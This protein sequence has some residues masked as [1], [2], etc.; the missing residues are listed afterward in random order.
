[1]LAGRGLDCVVEGE[2]TARGWP[3]VALNLLVHPRDFLFH[4]WKAA[5]ADLRD[6]ARRVR[7]PAL[8]AWGAGDHT[9]PANAPAEFHKALPDARLYVSA[10]GSHDWLIDRPAEFAAAVRDFV[11]G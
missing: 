9:L 6:Q 8:V 2:L 7:A 5:R 11:C 3:H 1:M 4:V 10:T